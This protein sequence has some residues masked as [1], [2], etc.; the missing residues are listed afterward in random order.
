MEFKNITEAI[1]QIAV[2]Q[3]KATE[4]NTSEDLKKD[5]SESLKALESFIL[6]Q[7]NNEPIIEDKKS[8]VTLSTNEFIDF[9]ILKS[10]DER[11]SALRNRQKYS[12]KDLMS[13]V[14]KDKAKFKTLSNTTTMADWIPVEFQNQV[15]DLIIEKTA[16]I[17]DFIQN[18]F[19]WSTG[20][21]TRRY[22][23]VDWYASFYGVEGTTITES[24]TSDLYFDISA[25]PFKG[26]YKW[27]DE[28]DMFTVVEML[29][30]LR[31]ALYF[32]L[33][34]SIE[35]SII[36]GDSSLSSPSVRRYWDGLRR[37]A[38]DAYNSA[39]LSTF[40]YTNFRSLR[41]KLAKYGI[42]PQELLIVA[43]ESKA[44][45]KMLNDSN[46]LTIDKVGA[47]ATILTGQLGIY[48]GIPVRTSSVLPLTDSTGE[49]S[50]TPANNTYG[51]ILV[52]NKRPFAV[53]FYGS[54]IVEWDK[55]ITIG[56][57][58]LVMRQYFGFSAIYSTKGVAL[59]YKM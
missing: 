59:G 38:I 49:I 8:G 10:I 57:T 6:T 54:P 14:I 16:V 12:E 47:K 45:Y 33:S 51:S 9:M 24:N 35:D 15:I 11:D 37:L 5:M 1:D 28:V 55:D 23:Y 25:K 56:V 36:N 52:V 21:S 20:S 40:N 30:I 17:A 32:G 22:P 44:Y 43:E 13:L 26:L 48:D 50:G 42:R 7:K 19:R 41:Q 46:F 2:L 18:I 58:Y 34:I 31:N 3:K 27:T 53:G 29:P 39:D 4:F